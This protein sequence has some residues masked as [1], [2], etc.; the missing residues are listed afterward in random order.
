MLLLLLITS[1]M[2]VIYCKYQSRLLFISIQEHEKNLDRY[3]VEWGQLQL[4][5]TTLI[6]HGRVE[7][8]ARR[9]LN[10]VEPVRDQIVHIIY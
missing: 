7:R 10:M 9:K 3:E 5:M 4:E 1:A 8:M 2:A 6:E